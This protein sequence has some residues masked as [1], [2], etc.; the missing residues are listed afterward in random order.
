MAHK[1]GLDKQGGGNEREN[2]DIAKKIFEILDE[3]VP[4]NKKDAGIKSY[5]ELIAY[6][7]DRP[8]HDRRYSIDT[9]KIEQELGWKAEENFESGITK[10]VEWYLE[11]LKIINS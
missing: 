11:K 6:V 1:T 4:L 3:K 2:I 8:G 5:R 10:T 9:N 7:E